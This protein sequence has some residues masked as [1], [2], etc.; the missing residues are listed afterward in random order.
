ML[1]GVM[2]LGNFLWL[3]IL[4]ILCAAV[5]VYY[6]FRVIQAMYFKEPVQIEEVDFSKSFGYIMLA[7]SII[8]VLLG[9]HP[10]WLLSFLNM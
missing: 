1:L 8:I 7:N 5:S 2:K 10:D 3:V 6:Y 9:V 4:A